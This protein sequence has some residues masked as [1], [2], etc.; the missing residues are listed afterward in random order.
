MSRPKQ[1]LNQ[2]LNQELDQRLDEEL[3]SAFKREVPSA[4]F[5]LRVLERVSLEPPPRARWWQ[6][7]AMLLEPPRLRWVA[8]GVTASLLLAIGAVQYSRLQQRVVND[9][10]TVAGSGSSRDDTKESAKPGS[11]AVSKDPTIVTPKTAQN[12][13]HASALATNHRPVSTRHQQERELRAEGEAA[14]EKL[15]LALAI[16]SS[17]LSDAQKAVHD[18]GV[19]P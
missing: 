18:N 8:I 17:A 6:R 1:G 11:D 13:K 9:G 12:I 5:T 19:E 3:R 10:G 7:L 4:D 16:A 15:M 14:K 2:G